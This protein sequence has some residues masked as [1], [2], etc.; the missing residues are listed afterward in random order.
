M[1]YRGYSINKGET[2]PQMIM[3]DASRVIDYLM[4]RNVSKEQIVVFGRSIGSAISL[5]VLKQH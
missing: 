5:S 2:N 1:E 3:K 4:K